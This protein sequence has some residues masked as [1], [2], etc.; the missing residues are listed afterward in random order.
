MSQRPLVAPGWA[1]DASYPA[2]IDPWSGQPN[3]SQPSA[4]KIGTGFIPNTDVAAEEVNYE[5]NNVA[6]FSGY[7]DDSV[8]GFAFWVK[9]DF[10]GNPPAAPNDDLWITT[11][12]GA[13]SAVQINDDSAGGG[14]GAL[15]QTVDAGGGEASIRTLPLPLGA[16]DFRISFRVRNVTTTN[17]QIGMLSTVV[18]EN[19]YF[20][21]GPGANWH[22]VVGAVSTDTGVPWLAT[23]Q[24]LEV[25]RSNGVVYFNIAGVLVYTVAFAVSITVGKV[26]SVSTFASGDSRLDS[27]A[28]WIDR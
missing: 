21:V 28:A 19:A 5:L 8:S 1:T 11:I 23:Y 24:K 22:A 3:K 15:R 7:L 18:G 13:G 12:V 17:I 4:G 14:L 26:S 9:D 25:I 6:G 10:I 20:Q 27:L 16:V 2:G